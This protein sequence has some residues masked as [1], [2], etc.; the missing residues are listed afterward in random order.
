MIEILKHIFSPRKCVV[1]LINGIL[2]ETSKESVL[3]IDRIRQKAVCSTGQRK[4][5]YIIEYN[6]TL[7]HYER[8]GKKYFIQPK[9]FKMIL[10]CHDH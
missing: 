3:M 4:E 1:V 8:Y 2:Y 9:K 10:P 5:F 7:T 6:K